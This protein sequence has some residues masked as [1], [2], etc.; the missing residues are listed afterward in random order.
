MPMYWTSELALGFSEIDDQHKEIIYRINQLVDACANGLCAIETQKMLDYLHTYV[1]KH[2]S[3]E[4]GIM[5]EIA[6]PKMDEHIEEHNTFIRRIETL[7]ENLR[8]GGPQGNILQSIAQTLVDWMFDHIWMH[9]RE[10]ARYLRNGAQM[11][12]TQHPA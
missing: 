3:G 6:Y 8:Q 11:K 4:E 12:R 7:R 9:D 5:E 1:D 2:F 10:L